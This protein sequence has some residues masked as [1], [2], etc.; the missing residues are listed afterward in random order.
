MNL[1]SWQGK[2]ESTSLGAPSE[3]TRSYRST[4]RVWPTNATIVSCPNCA[5]RLSSGRIIRKDHSLCAA[6]AIMNHCCAQSI[7][8]VLR[9]ADPTLTSSAAHIM[10]DL[11]MRTTASY[12]VDDLGSRSPVVQGFVRP[13][14]QTRDGLAV[15][16]ESLLDAVVVGDDGSRRVLQRKDLPDHHAYNRHLQ[17]ARLCGGRGAALADTV[18]VAAFVGRV[19]DIVYMLSSYRP[20]GRNMSDG[21]PAHLLPSWIAGEILDVSSSDLPW[22][23]N[24]RKH[25]TV[26]YEVQAKNSG[27][28]GRKA[29]ALPGGQ[30]GEPGVRCDVVN[31]NC[32]VISDPNAVHSFSK[33][34]VEQARTPQ[35]IPTDADFLQRAITRGQNYLR[36]RSGVHQKIYSDII[37]EYRSR[38]L[39]QALQEEVAKCD[40]FTE[41]GM[42]LR[43]NFAIALS[44]S[45]P[46]ARIVAGQCLGYDSNHMAGRPVILSNAQLRALHNAKL[47][48]ADPNVE[49]LVE[50]KIQ[51]PCGYS[52][53]KGLKGDAPDCSGTHFTTCRSVPTTNGLRVQYHDRCVDV[54]AEVIHAGNDPSKV[55]HGPFVSKS[56]LMQGT[57]VALQQMS[58]AGV[59][60]S[61]LVR[62][63]NR[64]P[65]IRW[66]ESER[67]GGQRATAQYSLDVSFR[68][69]GASLAAVACTCD[70]DGLSTKYGRNVC[71]CFGRYRRPGMVAE[72]RGDVFKIDKHHATEAE[73]GCV[74]YPFSLEQPGAFSKKARSLLKR[75]VKR[76]YDRNNWNAAFF[77]GVFRRG[78]HRRLVSVQSR[79]HSSLLVNGPSAVITSHHRRRVHLDYANN[80]CAYFDCAGEGE[81]VYCRWEQ[82]AP[83]GADGGGGRQWIKVGSAGVGK[84]VCDGQKVGVGV[85]KGARVEENVC[86][87]QKV[88]VEVGE[89]AW[90]G[91]NVCGGQQVGVDV[92]ETERGSEGDK[93][94]R[95]GTEEA[96]GGSVW[97]GRGRV[98]QRTGA[99]IRE[100]APVQRVLRADPGNGCGT[101]NQVMSGSDEVGVAVGFRTAE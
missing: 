91:E 99:A 44:A 31:H 75:L 79:L 49:R 54:L 38:L 25:Y 17:P 74:F 35:P 47:G 48:T 4:W 32:Q 92:G 82:D 37:H 33:T 59:K 80:P 29:T 101:G 2:S 46:T 41:N 28:M 52:W 19:T 39:N 14:S 34:L 40:G 81:A 23:Q 85:G 68:S 12:H 93:V 9:M 94:G 88:G 84:N 27:S 69:I 11:I 83:R 60:L 53:A 67:R 8:H 98:E 13:P 86:G 45:A 5:H 1:C 64:I 50:M 96:G 72:S 62:K 6:E 36:L 16:G 70:Q 100:S 20:A 90:V 21:E 58:P 89:G 61:G 63:D 3:A 10:D 24:F 73:Q 77:P 78:V 56:D 18:R 76:V 30:L 97:S 66:S 87:E 65:D 26:L 71:C 55:G 15:E 57:A 7:Y 42:P 95:K 43:V 51:C 22:A